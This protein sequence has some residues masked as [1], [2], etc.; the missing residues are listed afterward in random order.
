[1][2]GEIDVKKLF[3]T[4]ALAAAGMVGSVAVAHAQNPPPPAPPGAPPAPPP[5]QPGQPPPADFGVAPAALPPAPIQQQGA[6]PPV[7][8]GTQQPPPADSATPPP[9]K[10]PPKKN[11]FRL[12]RFDWTNSA[13]TK[14]FGIGANPRDSFTGQKGYIGHE[15]E[16]YVMDF[17]FRFRYTFFDKP[18]DQIF[19]QFVLPW[20]VE[21]TNSDST[22]TKREVQLRDLSVAIGYFRNAYKSEGGAVTL[23]N[24]V[25]STIFPTSIQS[26]ARGQYLATNL[27]LQAI[28][29]LPL[30]KSDW[31][32]DV[33]LYGGGR[34]AHAFTRATQATNEGVPVASHYRMLGGAA[35]SPSAASTD[36]LGTRA[37]A[38]DTVALYAGFFLTVYKDFSLSNY[39][40]Y[41]MPFTRSF[42]GSDCEA[43]VANV[44]GGCVKADRVSNPTTM[45]PTTTFDIQVNY[46][47]PNVRIDVGYQNVASQI[48]E[49]GKRQTVFYSPS[50]MFYVNASVFVD[51][52]IWKLVN[53]DASGNK[54]RISKSAGQTGAF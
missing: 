34:W 4:M 26:R 12:T 21:L 9:E 6:P 19:A 52:F 46:Q 49:D 53:P 15:D 37:L 35:G 38:Q 8:F 5:G 36:I 16:Q 40:E 29:I 41:A 44:A 30:V 45:M 3:R 22:R 54:S 10:K 17:S 51:N 39:W 33:F 27:T 11:P 7:A 1:V 14:I 31:L 2:I 28:Q 32:S 13:T 18:K 50:S 43:P 20:S 42:K 47:L 25:F 24:P 48:G 23:L